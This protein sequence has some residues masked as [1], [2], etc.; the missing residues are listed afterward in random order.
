M[1]YMILF[2]DLFLEFIKHVVCFQCYPVLKNAS[3]DLFTLIFVYISDLVPLNK[4]LKVELVQGFP[5][6]LN[7]FVLVSHK[8]CLRMLILPHLASIEYYLLICCQFWSK[9]LIFHCWKVNFLITK[10]VGV[11]PPICVLV[12]CMFSYVKFFY[13]F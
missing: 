10:K 13:L 12:S 9:K 6:K 8:Y 11:F 3:E 2:S 4:F 7:K 1:E 5:Q